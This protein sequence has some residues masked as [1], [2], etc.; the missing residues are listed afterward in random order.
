MHPSVEVIKAFDGLI[1][2]VLM[3]VEGLFVSFRKS[4]R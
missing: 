2:D 3:K 4:E 1:V